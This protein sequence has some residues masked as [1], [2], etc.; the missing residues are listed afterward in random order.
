[1]GF[2]FRFHIAVA[3][4]TLYTEFNFQQDWF[5]STEATL[6]FEVNISQGSVATRFICVGLL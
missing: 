6:A 1:M 5:C 2:L 4:L 3:A